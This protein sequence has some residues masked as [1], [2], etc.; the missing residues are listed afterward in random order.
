MPQK[1]RPEQ[2][3]AHK[4]LEAKV[5]RRCCEQEQPR[6]FTE[7]LEESHPDSEALPFALR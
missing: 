5:E 4:D 2:T 1:G 6:V 7:D 3:C